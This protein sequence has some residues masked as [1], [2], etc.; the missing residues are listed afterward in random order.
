MFTWIPIHREAVRKMLELQEPQKEI[1]AVLREM[2]QKQLRVTGLNDKG[3]DTVFPL[4][5]IDPLTFLAMFNRGISEQNRRHNWQFLKAR[6]HLSSGLPQDFDG[7][8]TVNN[9]SSWFFPYSDKRGKQDV[10]R[11]WQLVRQVADRT[12]EEVDGPLFDQCLQIGAVGIH[13]LTIGMFWV[14]PGQFL[15][16]DK[17]TRRYGRQKDIHV[18]PKNYASYCEWMS[19]MS[20]VFGEEYPKLSHDAHLWATAEGH[21]DDTSDDE[22]DWDNGQQK[23]SAR[24]W[25]VAPGKGAKQWDEFYNAGIIAINWQDIF[26]DLREFAD[27]EAIRQR[28]QEHEGSNSSK[29]NDT[30]ACWQFAHVMKPGDI[31]F[32]KRGRSTILGYGILDGAYKYDS[33]RKSFKHGHAVRW[34]A[35]GEWPLAP[36]DRLPLK[37]VTEITRNTDL[38]ERI[39]KLVGFDLRTVDQAPTPASRLGSNEHVSY[40]WLNANP[41]IWSFEGLAIGE[42]QTYTSHNDNGNKRQKYRYFHDVKPGDVLVGYVTS[43]QREIVGICT[44]TKGLHQGE[45]REQIEFEKTERLKKPVL[46]ET[47]KSIPELEKAEPLISH[48]GSLFKL[49]EEEYEAIRSLIDETNP[50]GVPSPKL[51][52]KQAAM[53]G[54]FLSEAQ[55]DEAIDALRE[56]KNIVL[57]GPPGVG[58]TFLARRLAKALIGFDDP[59][60]IEMIQFHQSYSYEDFIQG[61]RPTTKGTF[62]LRY[63]VFHQFCRRAQ[64]D[65]ATDQKYVFVIDEINRGNLSK[66]FGELMMLVE[67]DKRGSEFAIPL[68][69]ASDSSD[70]FYIPDNLYLIGT[71]NTADRSLAMVDYALRRRFRFLKLRPEFASGDFSSYLESNG[72]PPE[73]VR[74]IVGRME[75]LNKVIAA[76]TKNLGPGYEIGHS[77]FC[78]RDGEHP[79][80][81]WYERIVS[82]EIVPLIQEYWFDDE[83]KVDEQ[84]KALLS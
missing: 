10:E 25:V 44:I 71:M 22:T 16:C 75:A 74:T 6:W 33:S 37:T 52:T 42:R 11:L 34:L 7:I 31:V 70:K 50:F 58:K 39:S 79:G 68:A 66:I 12:P 80:D 61:F 83:K 28:L 64:R 14:S 53:Q 62:D 2:E 1:L 69:Y 41:Q 9:Q 19:Q 23:G 72:V 35:R 40:W 26:G 5:E 18:E 20:R 38:V 29:V 56:K 36:D 45:H 60:R 27:K 65:E 51:Y 24:F 15:P 84:R 32:A 78:P 73:L 54:L 3:G 59:Q 21:G 67:P 49:R 13:K 47:L 8:P 30:L 4:G 82:H 17:K 43:P 55:F 81:G 48:Q 46:Y 63:G 57:Q 76:D 77:Y